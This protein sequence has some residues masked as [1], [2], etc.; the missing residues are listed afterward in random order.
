MT[1]DEMIEVLQ[2]ARAGETIQYLT[3]AVDQAAYRI[4]EYVEKLT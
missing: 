3:E 2:A 4:V 1:I